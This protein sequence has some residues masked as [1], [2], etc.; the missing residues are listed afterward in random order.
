METAV[1]KRYM[2]AMQKNG[3]NQ[4]AFIEATK[5][6]MAQ[7]L[8]WDSTQT[9]TAEPQLAQAARHL[10]FAP[11]AKHAR[12]ILVYCLG[13]SVQADDKRLIDAAVAAEFI[14][15]ASLLHDDV[16]DSGE[17]RRGRECVNV[18]WD[19]LTAV[20]AGDLLLAEAIKGLGACPRAL[21]GEALE[22][23]ANMSRSTM[24]EAQIRGSLTMSL[25]QWHFIANGKTAG[26]FK[27]CGRA[28]AHLG[29]H[30]TALSHFSEF[31]R[32]FGLA[33]QLADDLLDLDLNSNKTP[34]ADI[35]NQNASYPLILAMTMSDKFRNELA[36]LWSSPNTSEKEIMRL[37]NW[38]SKSDAVSE[39]RQQAIAL[40]ERAITALGPYKDNPHCQNVS[41]WAKILAQRLQLAEA[42]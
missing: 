22:V 3:L 38:L 4:T 25:D 29:H 41:E 40:T 17:M 26:I 36:A 32:L 39:S 20:L 19:P 2:P 1:N 15:S 23:V 5:K 28:A 10:V 7:A 24:L 34:F 13:R 30:E 12:P 18:K 6:Q 8:Y 31:G 14:H 21:T 27:W 33:F 16:I 11:G 35:R 37:G 9:N 42:V